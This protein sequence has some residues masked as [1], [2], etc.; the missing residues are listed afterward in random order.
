MASSRRISLPII[1]I[2]FCELLC[3]AQSASTRFRWNWRKNETDDW[4]SVSKSKTLSPKD[5]AALIDALVAQFRPSVSKMS[6]QEVREF[7]ATQIRVKAVDLGGHGPTEYLAL[8]SDHEGCSPTGNCEA[9]VFKQTKDGYSKILHRTAT[10]TFTIQPTITNG[11]HDLVLGQHGSAT[12]A[13]L[14]LYRFD[15]AKYRRLA[16]YDANCEYLGKDGEYHSLKEPRI[17]PTICSFR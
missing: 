14:T 3:S 1:L 5:R 12:D 13:G 9:W 4:Q 11:F 7:V 17:T 6:D 8:S 16:C 10:Q 2:C 15:G